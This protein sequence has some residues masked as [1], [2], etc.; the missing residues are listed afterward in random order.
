MYICL[1]EE[2]NLSLS[3]I[4]LLDFESVPMVWYW[5]NPT[6]SE[7]NNKAYYIR[8]PISCEV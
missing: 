2:Y 5:L 1:L 6:I 8:S 3:T 7:Y 4:F